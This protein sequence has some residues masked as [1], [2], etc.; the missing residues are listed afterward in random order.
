MKRSF[1]LGVMVAFLIGFSSGSHAVGKFGIEGT[2]GKSSLGLVWY[3]EAYSGGVFF[4]QEQ[5][6]SVQRST[7][8]VGV[9]AGL[10]HKLEPRLFFN[11]GL[12]T[13]L[14]TGV[15]KAGT[16]RNLEIFGLS[17]FIGF[18]YEATPH[19]LLT[20]W[21][22]VFDYNITKIESVSTTTTT[23]IFQSYAG[24]TYLF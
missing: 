3:E 12:N 11:Y 6:E 15:V 14:R 18:E 22:N 1:V 9:W 2:L 13:Y 17:P 20:A 23:S 4:G 21:C 24:I 7:T 10:R 8:T 16:G 19:F 5:D